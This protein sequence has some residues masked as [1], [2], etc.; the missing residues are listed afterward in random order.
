MKYSYSRVST[1]ARYL[2]GA[3]RITVGS[4]SLFVPV[5]FGRS[6]GIDPEENPAAIYILRLFGVRT[7][8]IG[9]Q[10]LLLGARSSRQSIGRR[11]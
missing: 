2:L 1:L 10:L 6:L 3:I 11:R 9:A 7:L 5:Q 4:A 8:V